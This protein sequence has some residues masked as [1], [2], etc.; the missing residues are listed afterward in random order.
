MAT[1]TDYRSMMDPPLVDLSD[2]FKA[3]SDTDSK[4]P[5]IEHDRATPVY[6]HPQS[7]IEG[8][9]LGGSSK[10]E[11]YHGPFSS[12]DCKKCM[13]AAKVEIE[14]RF[15]NETLTTKYIEK[16]EG[17]V[18][19]LQIELD[20]SKS[21]D[22]YDL[23]PVLPYS[24]PQKIIQHPTMGFLEG[25]RVGPRKVGGPKLAISRIKKVTNQFGNEENLRDYEP[26]PGDA[27]MKM[28]ESKEI[29]TVYRH[30]SNKMEPWMTSVEI[31]S[32]PFVKVL[33]QVA[34]Y[35]L[36]IILNNEVMRLTEPLMVLFHYRK[37]LTQ[38]LQDNRTK[39]T[40]M[41]TRE[42]I[43]HTKFILDY[44]R[45]EIEDASRTLD[46]L[47]S[48]HP[49][50]L[51]TYPDIWLLYPP[52][53]VGY[54]T[55]NGEHEAFI[56]D[57]V[58]GMAKQQRSRSGKQHYGRLELICW[59][60]N[61][62]G[63]IFGREW[64]T[65]IIPPFSG[66]K[67]ISSLDF[68]PE[69]FLPNANTVKESLKARGR[70]FWDLQGQNY[71]EYTGEIWSQRMSEDSIRVMVD[72]LTYQRRMNW[73]IVID[74]KRGPSGALSKNWR[75]NKFTLNGRSYDTYGDDGRS[76]RKRGPPPPP[77]VPPQFD[78]DRA[79][80]P[81]GDFDDEQ[82]QQP[83]KRYKVDRPALRGDS[84]FNRYNSLDPASK[85]DD[86]TLL[87]CPQH[88]HGYCLRDKIWS[89]QSTLS[90]GIFVDI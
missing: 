11:L 87:L 47:E 31:F 48:A 74:K 17:L 66:T 13:E 3:P 76:R 81:D 21:S 4:E 27:S 73:P 60:I 44:M 84:K 36:D 18:N 9:G 26:G 33:R 62:D 54:T 24:P 42:S 85:P 56:V 8:N 15:S 61:Y 51:I 89:T 32:P 57:S 83:Y 45:D 2:A 80:N 35:D 46:D 53:T 39:H 52:G 49:S 86:L 20:G 14:K 5:I 1:A 7:P 71:H 28:V 59:S 25:D 41:L 30:F 22:F 75:D 34:E 58:H 67:E 72:H 43:D 10:V 16:L 19:S 77:R 38:Y 55:E 37:L 79:Y 68:V 63:E 23:P 90:L 82:Y 40:D 12:C 78:N 29:L 69:K 50:G 70:A 88:V 6:E 64:T 65:H